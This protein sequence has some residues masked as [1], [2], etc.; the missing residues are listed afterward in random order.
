MSEE[1]FFMWYNTE[2]TCEEKTLCKKIDE[3]SDNFNDMLFRPGTA[4]GALLLYEK[5]NLDGTVCEMHDDAPDELES[6]N[7][8]SIRMKVTKLDDFSGYYD[9]EKKLLCIS[10]DY[11]SDDS[12]ILHEMIHLHENVLNELPMYFHDSLFW[13]LYSD[14]KGKLVDL[15]EA[16][17]EHAHI[18]HEHSLYKRGGNHDITFLLKSLDLDIRMGYPLGRVFGYGMEDKLRDLKRLD[19]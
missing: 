4:S 12:V 15:D 11:L 9:E 16:I 2:A 6:F 17:R 13:A 8:D 19:Q 1:E 3:F 14:L 18:L 10:S 7:Y 5:D